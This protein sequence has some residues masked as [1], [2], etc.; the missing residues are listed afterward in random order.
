MA[1]LYSLRKAGKVRDVSNA[2]SKV[3]F[4]WSDARWKQPECILVNVQSVYDDVVLG[5][6]VTQATMEAVINLAG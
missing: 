3:I 2:E 1:S 4:R 6:T 5:S